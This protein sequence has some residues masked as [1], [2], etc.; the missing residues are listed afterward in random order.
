MPLL[1]LCIREK[2]TG[3]GVIATE[4]SL[5]SQLMGKYLPV[6]YSTALLLIWSMAYWSGGSGQVY[7][8]Q[9]FPV[10]ESNNRQ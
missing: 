9:K 5:F 6:F 7:L 1:F 2:E 4:V 8:P 3:N 10:Q